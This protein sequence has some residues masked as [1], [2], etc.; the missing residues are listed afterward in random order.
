M[1]KKL[2][3]EAGAGKLPA[4]EG[5]F[6]HRLYRL[7]AHR[8]M[9]QSDVAR[10]IWGE[11]TDNRGYVV[12]KNRDRISAYEGG[13]SVP[14]KTTLEALAELFGVSLAELAPDLVLTGRGTLGGGAPEP[15]LSV[16]VVPGTMDAELRV[17][18]IVPIGVAVKVVEML[19]KYAGSAGASGAAGIGDGSGAA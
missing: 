7:R 12:A 15:N 3:E 13:R 18:M 9:S 5:K 1:K 10:A 6:P 11:T 14:E 4:L 17:N 19:Q 8:G 16:S 2:P